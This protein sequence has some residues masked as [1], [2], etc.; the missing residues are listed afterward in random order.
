[1]VPGAGGAGG[2][3]GAGAA[4]ARP[5]GKGKGEEDDEHERPSYLVEGDPESTFGNDQLTAPSVIGG[6]DD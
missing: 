5:R 4:W 2:R 3:G 6:D 1:M